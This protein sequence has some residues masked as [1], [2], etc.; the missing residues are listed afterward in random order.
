[1][2]QPEIAKDARAG[3]SYL[4][5]LRAKLREEIEQLLFLD[6]VGSTL[7]PKLRARMDMIIVM[8]K[9]IDALILKTH[10]MLEGIETMLREFKRED[11]VIDTE[12]EPDG[13]NG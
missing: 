9:D 12:E 6:H 5:T 10:S 3:V 13:D 2:L 7:N 1:M 8:Y 4:N 11:M